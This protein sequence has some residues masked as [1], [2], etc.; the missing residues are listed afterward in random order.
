MRAAPARALAAADAG[1]RIDRGDQDP[2]VRFALRST[3]GGALFDTG[4]RSGG[5]LE[6]QEAHAELGGRPVPGPLAAQAALLESRASL[7]LGSSAAA[8][9]SMGRLAGRD[10]MRGRAHAARGLVGGGLRRRDAGPRDRRPILNGVLRPVLPT[11]LVEAWLVEVWAALRLGDRPGARRA[12]Q[13]ALLRAG[14]L[15]HLRPFAL[16][17]QGMRVLLV[18]QLGGTRDPDDFAVRCWPR[19]ARRAGHDAR[20]ERPRARRPHR[21]ASLA[22]SGRSPGTSTSRS[23]P[24]RATSGRSTAS[25]A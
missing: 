15:D 21:A 4:D 1:L 18:D 3:R 17:G 14:P 10:G 20:S 11:T 2:V 19:A 12:L 6:L 22:T 25:S 23:T 9:T 13:A 24:S 5:L 8:A 16:A 7:V